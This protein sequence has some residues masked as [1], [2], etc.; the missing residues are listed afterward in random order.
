MRDPEQAPVVRTING[1][2]RHLYFRIPHFLRSRLQRQ[3]KQTIRM[4]KR[5]RM[6][7][8]TTSNA[9]CYQQAHYACEACQTQVFDV[10]GMVEQRWSVLLARVAAAF[11]RRL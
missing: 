3:I 6:T 2:E 7:A 1:N 9:E 10:H 8:R 5:A 4:L 11:A